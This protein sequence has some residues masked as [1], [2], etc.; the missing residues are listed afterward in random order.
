[1][2]STHNL[3]LTPQGEKDIVDAYEWYENQGI[4]LGNEFV[5]CIDDKLNAVLRNPLHYQIIHKSIIRR[6]LV[7]RFPSLIYFIQEEN[8]VVVFAILHQH[9]NSNF[10]QS[11][12]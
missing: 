11:R 4:G 5:R 7:N 10:W 2:G 6:A 8:S 12:G 3:L 1:M 9:R